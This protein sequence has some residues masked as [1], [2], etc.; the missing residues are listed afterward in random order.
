MKCQVLNCTGSSPKRK[1]KTG[2]RNRPVFWAENVPV[3]S[4]A[5]IPSQKSAGHHAR[6]TLT[7]ALVFNADGTWWLWTRSNAACYSSA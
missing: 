3:D 1:W 5:I 7:L 2:K 6:Q 4:H